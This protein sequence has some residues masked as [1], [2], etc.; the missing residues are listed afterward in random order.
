MTNYIVHLKLR[1]KRLIMKN[2]LLCK[3]E[4]E[5]MSG[6][7]LKTGKF[8]EKVIHGYKAIENAVVGGY[9]KIEGK[10]VDAFLEKVDDKSVPIAPRKDL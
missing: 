3:M 5:N 7:K 2:N 10:F 9:K 4:A 8:A 6:Y 1:K